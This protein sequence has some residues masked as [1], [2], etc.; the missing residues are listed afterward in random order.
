MSNRQDK[1]NA[2]M[3]HFEANAKLNHGRSLPTEI[4]KE[5]RK[6]LEYKSDNKINRLYKD[7]VNS[8]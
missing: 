2:L 7:L 6:Q 4:S 1:I 5:L 8:L 3:N